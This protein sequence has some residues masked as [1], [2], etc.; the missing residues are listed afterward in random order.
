MAGIPSPAQSLQRSATPPAVPTG[1]QTNYIVP[2]SVLTTLFLMWGGLTSLNDVLIPH[3]KNIFSL[4]YAGA[5]D[6]QLYFFGAYGVMS[7]PAG[8]FVKKIGFKKGIIVGLGIAALGCLLFYPAASVRLM[9]MFKAAVFVLA[10]GIVILQVA[11]N[12]FV[13]VLGR[14]ETASSRLTL[15]QAFNSFATWSFP[16]FIG[17][18]ILAVAGLA[19]EE[20]AKLTPAALQ[21]KE[22]SAIQFPYVGLAVALALL[23]VIVWRSKLPKIDTATTTASTA[24]T[25]AGDRGS[26]WRYRHLV[27]GAV[28]IFIYVGAEVAI[29]SLLVNYFKEPYTLGLPENKGTKVMAWYWLCAMIG[30]FIGSYT[31]RKFRP[32]R[33]L[34]I[35]AVVASL[36]VVTSTFTTGYVAV[37]SIIAVGLFNSIMFPTIFTLAI[38]GLGRHTEQGSGILC[39]AIL[40][41][42]VIPKLQGM[43]ADSA[44]LHI[45]FLLPA[46]CYLYIAWYGLKGH[47]T[48]ARKP[49]VAAA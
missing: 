10:T 19:P 30:R 12:P 42:A 17:P 38:D 44:G 1:P 33:L 8:W 40:G 29:G 4:N 6:V 3:L 31:L 43:F 15:T 48:D 28:G 21:A 27:L 47:A 46:V 16:T 20:L 37:G 26:A 25:S 5:M 39:A 18:I 11:A 23:S 14:P 35:H 9:G 34:A 49:G 7:I 41:G 45:S 22:A 13:A 36:L 2:L 32:G 24:S